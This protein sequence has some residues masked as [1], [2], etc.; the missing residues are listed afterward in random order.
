MIRK[1]AFLCCFLTLLSACATTSP[2]QVDKTSTAAGK[3]SVGMELPVFSGTGLNGE[4]VDLAKVKGEKPI[5]L[6]FWTTWCGD[7]KNKMVAVN[8]MVEKYHRD[9]EIVGI[10]VGMNDSEEKAKTYIIENGMTFPNVFDKTGELSE[11]YGLNKVFAIVIAS[12][13]GTTV[14]KLNSEPEI[15]DTVLEMLN[16]YSHNLQ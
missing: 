8:A 16:S 9:I 15:D 7:C 6:V 10:N 2:I 1:F 12:K 14:M 4:Y 3:L 11:A 5:M 13:D